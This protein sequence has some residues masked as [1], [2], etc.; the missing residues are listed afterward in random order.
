[1]D[2]KELEALDLLHYSPVYVNGGVFSPPFPVVYDHLLCFT[3]RE[4]LLS[5]HHTA[6]S[7]T[8]SL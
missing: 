3:L 4:R 2:P 7:L 8:S 1:M 6:M 5:W